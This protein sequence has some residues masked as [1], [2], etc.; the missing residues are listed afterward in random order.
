MQCS[1]DWMP[2]DRQLMLF[3]NDDLF[4]YQKEILKKLSEYDKNSYFKRYP[5]RREK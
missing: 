2:L 3:L 5:Q 4:D 1:K